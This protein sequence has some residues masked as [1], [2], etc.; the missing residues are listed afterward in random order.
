MRTISKQEGRASLFA[1]LL[2]LFVAALAYW[3]WRAHT[4]VSLEIGLACRQLTAEACA[5]AEARYLDSLYAAW[6]G[7]M[8]PWI[9]PFIPAFIYVFFFRWLRRNRNP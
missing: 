6:F 8:F 7:Q 9:L 3:F 1:L 4:Q 2:L 5:A